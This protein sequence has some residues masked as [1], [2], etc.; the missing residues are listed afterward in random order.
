MADAVEASGIGLLP[1]PQDVAL[2]LLQPVLVPQHALL[3]IGIPMPVQQ[4]L[5][6]SLRLLHH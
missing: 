4:L 5:R 6:R 2:E 1:H 3:V